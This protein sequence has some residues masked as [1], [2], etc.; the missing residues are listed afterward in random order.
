VKPARQVPSVRADLKA[1]RDRKAPLGRKA[2]PVSAANPGRLARKDR[3][4][5]KVRRAKLVHR[6]PQG[7]P[8]NAAKRDHKALQVRPVRQDHQVPRANQV[9]RL[10]SASSPGRTTRGAQTMRSWFHWCARAARLTVRSAPRP[11]RQRPR[12]ARG[13]DL[14]I[15]THTRPCVGGSAL[16]S[17]N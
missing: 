12:C 1:R 11:A 6:G 13:N 10:R 5:L 16:S 8:A 17:E 7:L 14:K 9:R 15:G 4:V 2:P 3:L